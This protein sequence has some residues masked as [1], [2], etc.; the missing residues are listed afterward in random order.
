MYFHVP[1]AGIP[2]LDSHLDQAQVK[3]TAS[4]HLRLEVQRLPFDSSRRSRNWDLRH[5]AKN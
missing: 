5:F 1:H 3:G 4:V 2:V